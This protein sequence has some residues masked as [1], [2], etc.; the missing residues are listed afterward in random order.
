MSV[1]TVKYLQVHGHQCRHGGISAGARASVSTRWNIC[2]CTGISVD[3]VEYICR[4]TG[5][6]VDTVEY[7]QVHGHQC[8]HCV[9]SAGARV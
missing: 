1:D 3:T 4:Y 2:R 7:L 9:I 5:I 6:S 8:R